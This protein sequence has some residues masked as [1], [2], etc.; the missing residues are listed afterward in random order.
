LLLIAAGLSADA[1]AVSLGNGLAMPRFRVRQAF[2]V[3]I[4]FGVFQALMPAIGYSLGY[5]IADK[6]AAVDHIAALVL[7]GF[8]GGRMVFGGAR[9]LTREQAR[10]QTQG[11]ETVRAQGQEE[12]AQT[13]DHPSAKALTAPGLIVQAIATSIDALIVGVSFAAVGLSWRGMIGAALAI[14]VFTFVLSFVGVALGK[15]FGSLLGSKAEIVG[16][17]IL[18]GIGLRIFVEHTF[19]S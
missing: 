19:F 11:E 2:A 3:A 15:K 1:F 7:L 18:L 5:M 8:I 16:G 17:A 12:H 10:A 13:Q 9:R 14:G 4:A 6:I